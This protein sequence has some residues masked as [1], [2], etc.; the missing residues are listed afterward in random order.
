M[1][2]SNYL[3][4][5]RIAPARIDAGISLTQLID[6]TFQAYNGARLREGCQ[7]LARKM[8]AADVTVG[9][10]IA[11][12]L[13]PAGLGMS[14]IIPL[15]EAGFVDWI[16]STGANLYHDTHFGL[17]L[18]L[19]EGS[20][21]LSDVDLYKEQVVRIYDVFLDFSVLTDTDDFFWHVIGAEEFQRTMST[22]EFHYRLGKYVAARERELG[23]GRKSLLAAAWDAAVPIF[24]SA[25]GDSTIGMNVAARAM[26]GGR[27]M[28]DVNADINES[29]SI[30]L[31]AKRAGGKSAVWILGGGTPKNFLLQTEPQLREVLGIDER[32]HDYFLQVTDARPDTGG[33]SGASPGEAVTWG[34]VD[35][36][37]LPDMVTC[38]VDSTVALP[39]L[40]A[41][42]LANRAPRAQK[43]L[44]ERRETMMERLRSE[45]NAVYSAQE[46]ARS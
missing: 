22:A 32:G 6:D 29:A 11:G 21:Q 12:A 41:Y 15:I 33:L 17:G 38:Y 43:R 16:V 30:V 25:P 4:G 14:A 40:T 36:D 20:H 8:L 23:I 26:A 7:L 3:S 19:H 9:L 46:R 13:T 28:F 42:A 34:K 37:Q 18:D 2:R 44:F 1:A 31:D 35:P 24:A 10:S 45:I 5:R 39:M 27:L